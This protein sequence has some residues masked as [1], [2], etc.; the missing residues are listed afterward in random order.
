MPES[1]IF[2]GRSPR[3]WLRLEQHDDK[4]FYANVPEVGDGIVL[5]ANLAESSAASCASFVDKMSRPFC[6]DP[7]SYRFTVPEWLLQERGEGPEKRNYSRLWKKYSSGIEPWSGDPLADAREVM[8]LSELN[9]A[10][11]A[12]NTLDYQD[13]Q[14]RHAWIS[15]AQTFVG[16]EPLFGTFAP[17]AYTAPYLIQTRDGDRSTVAAASLARLT[18]ELAKPRGTMAVVAMEPD[19]LDDPARMALIA[20]LYAS[21]GA[22]AVW[23]WTVG[24]PAIALADRPT[25]FTNY[26]R[27]VRTLS[28][29]GVEVGIMYGGFLAALLR[30]VGVKAISHGLMYGEVRGAVPA[31]GGP[32]PNFYWPPLHRFVNYERAKAM[33]ESMTPS[34]FLERVCACDIC[35]TL[36]T[37]PR[38]LNRYFEANRP[39]KATRDFPVRSSLELNRFHFLMARGQEMINLRGGIL[40]ELIDQLLVAATEFGDPS[41]EPLRV[42]VRRLESA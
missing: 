1:E 3:L 39:G 10:K 33:V 26:L 18:A 25:R 17:A 9:L 16:M 38:G 15:E 14:L 23:I 12:R 5:N 22:H 11:Y 41:K 32:L 30:F 2:D 27:L 7:V 4:A 8:S 28:D 37:E 20:K 21:C 13:F 34:E 6:F 36:V 35:R 40:P 19:L 29:A 24:L 42:W 31:G